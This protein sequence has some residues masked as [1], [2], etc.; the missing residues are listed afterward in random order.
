M[1]GR[2]AVCRDIGPRLSLIKLI[3]LIKL[4]NPINPINPINYRF[5]STLCAD[6]CE[7][8]NGM[9]DG[10]CA[11]TV[12]GWECSCPPPSQVDPR[13]PT[14][15]GASHCSFIRENMRVGL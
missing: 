15:C 2:P 8:D 6:E 7:T 9:C 14:R 4:I 10:A 1:D 3:K 11:N 5:V 13:S 12:G